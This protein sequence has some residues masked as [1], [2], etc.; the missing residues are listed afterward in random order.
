MG[1]TQEFKNILLSDPHAILGK[2][3][4]TDQFIDHTNKLL[5]RYKVIKIKA[6]KSVANKSNIKEIANKVANL[7]ESYLIDVRGL[8]FII[9]KNPL[10]KKD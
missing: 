1:Y 4:I 2:K 5:K 10:K 6:L 8:K 7:T 9:S 3:G